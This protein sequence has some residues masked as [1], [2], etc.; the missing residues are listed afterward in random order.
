MIAE[1][2]ASQKQ[3]SKQKNLHGKFFKKREINENEFGVDIE[4]FG[5]NFDD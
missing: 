3:E 2:I 4:Y 5:Y 1:R